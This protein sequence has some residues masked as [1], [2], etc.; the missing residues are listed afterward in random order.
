[1]VEKSSGVKPCNI[2]DTVA[3]DDYRQIIRLILEKYK[4]HPSILAIIQ[5]PENNFKLFSFHEVQ[6]CQVWEQLRSLDGRKSTGEDQIPPKF[7]LLAADELAAPLTDAITAAYETVGFQTMEN[8]LRYVPWIKGRP[9]VRLSE[10][11][12]LS[13]F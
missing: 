11:F 5:N 1:M 9:I 6:V 13:V 12:D 10:T 7:V 4:N 2:A 8:E 3:T